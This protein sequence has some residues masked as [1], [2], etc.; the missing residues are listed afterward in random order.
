MDDEVFR[1][2][3]ETI[4]ALAE[5]A[6]WSVEADLRLEGARADEELFA[7]AKERILAE[8]KDRLRRVARGLVVDFVRC[9]II[10]KALREVLGENFETEILGRNERV[11]I[12]GQ[13]DEAILPLVIDEG[14]VRLGDPPADAPFVEVAFDD[15][16]TRVPFSDVPPPDFC[17]V[18]FA[19]PEM[20]PDGSSTLAHDPRCSLGGSS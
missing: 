16:K 4:E 7:E 1:G 12:V 17:P 10:P 2:S 3:D 5:F 15:G 8:G 14:R 11:E 19:K 20:A 18:C 9:K 6:R 13:A